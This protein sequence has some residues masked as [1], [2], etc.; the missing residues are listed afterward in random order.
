MALTVEQI[1]DLEQYKNLSTHIVGILDR[2]AG[3]NTDSRQLSPANITALNDLYTTLIAD[4]E[5]IITPAP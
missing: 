1:A 5:T 2:E 3:I 4:I